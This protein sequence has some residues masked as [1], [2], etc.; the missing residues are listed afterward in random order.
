MGLAK[1]IYIRLFVRGRESLGALADPALSDRDARQI[2]CRTLCNRLRGLLRTPLMGSVVGGLFVGKR[3]SI[4]SPGHIHCGRNV[5]FED[6]AEIQGLSLKGVH[7]ADGVT[8]GRG[9][10]VRPSSYYGGALGQ[11]LRVGTQSSIGAYCWIGA[12]GQV[13]IGANVIIGPRV[14][15]IPENHNFEDPGLA[16]RN[17]GVTRADVAIEDDCWIG[18]SATILAGV[19]IGRGSIVAAGALVNRDVQAGSIVG[20]VPAKLIRLRSSAT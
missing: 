11:G 18:A 2:L 9:A 5:K 6:H 16:I 15:I 3:V 1:S 8:L 19:R 10:C 14:T 13:T 4:L 20:G 17:Q 12:S 7:F